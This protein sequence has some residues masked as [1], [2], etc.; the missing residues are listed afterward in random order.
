MSIPTLTTTRLT[1][2]SWTPEDAGALFSILQ[3][4]D[5]LRYYPNPT[6]PPMDK[7]ERYIARHLKHWQ[8]RGC[9]HWAAVAR[10]EQELI[11]WA[12]LEFLPETGETEVAYLLSKPFWGRGLATEAAR[13]AVQFGFDQAGLESIIG[14]THPENIASQ[15]VL[16]KCELAFTARKSYFGIDVFHY[17]I[18]RPSRE[19][20]Q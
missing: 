10:A 18:N 3:Q 19:S 8:E 7:V 2:R 5:I 15:R 14:L 20:A 11:G 16:Q 6:P 17:V 4:P 9:G 13:A 12:G 1:L